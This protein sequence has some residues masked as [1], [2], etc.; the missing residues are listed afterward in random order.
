[1]SDFAEHTISLDDSLAE[2][3]RLAKLDI[4]ID[5]RTRELF[6]TDGS[7]FGYSREEAREQAKLE[8]LGG[9]EAADGDNI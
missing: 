3:A 9:N 5:A 7:E 1:M 8:V 4:E 2:S 6:G